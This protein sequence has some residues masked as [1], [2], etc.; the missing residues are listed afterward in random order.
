MKT[1]IEMVR[2]VVARVIQDVGAAL[3]SQED[4][5]Q[6]A[7]IHLCRKVSLRP[8]Q[9]ESWY[10]QSCYFHLLGYLRQGTSVDAPKRR[11]L[12]CELSDDS[13]EAGSNHLVVEETVRSTVS[14]RD[15]R[16]VLAPLLSEKQQKILT[17]LEQGFGPVEVA[18]MLGISQP[19]VSKERPKI[20]AIAVRH[21]ITPL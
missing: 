16:A 14:A 17:L 19:A 9:T 4:L 12:A 10:S 21:G 6:E 11:H 13:E 7:F 15:I 5:I 2:A 1:A 8:G 3:D 20:A 18:G